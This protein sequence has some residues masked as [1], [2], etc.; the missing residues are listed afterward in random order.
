MDENNN[1]EFDSDQNNTGSSEQNIEQ[2]TEEK[3][4]FDFGTCNVEIN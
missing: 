4:S 2:N 3:Q 1:F